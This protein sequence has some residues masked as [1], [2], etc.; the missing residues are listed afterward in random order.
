MQNEAR[1]ISGHVYGV[2]KYVFG[3]KRGSLMAG[4]GIVQEECLAVSDMVGDAWCGYFGSWV[5]VV[6]ESIPPSQ[7]LVVASTLLSTGPS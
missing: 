7:P 6:D 3:M 2:Q 5:V 1:T 4:T